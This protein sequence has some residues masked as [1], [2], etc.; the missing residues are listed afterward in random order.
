[1]T[2]KQRT[3][4]NAKQAL[5]MLVG[6]YIMFVVIYIQKSSFSLSLQNKPQSFKWLKY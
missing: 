6:S 4:H 1:M 5:V 3:L 2:Y